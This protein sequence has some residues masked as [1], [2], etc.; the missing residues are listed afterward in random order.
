MAKHLSY[1]KGSLCEP[2]RS[3][4]HDRKFGGGVT[5]VLVLMTLEMLTV[6]VENEVVVERV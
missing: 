3:S 2:L 5:V 1:L 6:I 4:H